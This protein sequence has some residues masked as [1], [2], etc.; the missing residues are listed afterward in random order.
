VQ[1]KAPDSHYVGT[2]EIYMQVR[3]KCPCVI[4]ASGRFGC[5]G[6]KYFG[7]DK[8][9]NFF[10]GHF[11]GRRTS[12]DWDRKVNVTRKWGRSDI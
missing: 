9:T 3:Q 8:R 4:C 5:R 2:M 12:S 10:G 7:L 11:P 6:E 1:D